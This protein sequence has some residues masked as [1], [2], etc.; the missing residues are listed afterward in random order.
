MATVY[1]NAYITI[2]ATKSKNCQDGIFSRRSRSARHILVWPLEP[3]QSPREVDVLR[4][5]EIYARESWDPIL[6]GYRLHRRGWTLQE[7]ILSRRVVQYVE[8]ELVWHCRTA[9]ATESRPT[10]ITSAEDTSRT[11]DRIRPTHLPLRDTIDMAASRR[12]LSFWAECV[13]NYTFRQ[14]TRESDKLPAISGIIQAFQA[15]GMGRCYAGLWEMDFLV[16]LTWAS[17]PSI[18]NEGGW[19]PSHVRPRHPRAPSWSWASVDG[20]VAYRSD[21]PDF[22]GPPSAQCQIVD[23]S[24]TEIVLRGKVVN[25]ALNRT[26]TCVPEVER[27]NKIS[28]CH[29]CIDSE[30]VIGDITSTS[31]A[32][33]IIDTTPMHPE[34]GAPPGLCETPVDVICLLLGV[35]PTSGDHPGWATALILVRSDTRSDAYER[36]GINDMLEVGCFEG[37]TEREVTII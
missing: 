6:L 26:T 15:S 23:L 16:G 1:G 35:K 13:Q 24:D 37:A 36:V 29:H 18:S 27:D 7:H 10:L 34:L 32:T 11:M 19:K 4:E 8:H 17:E 12:L 31:T 20:M 3:G 22:L 5:G 2:S 21:R 30:L 28:G 9:R 25:G 14:L 33:D